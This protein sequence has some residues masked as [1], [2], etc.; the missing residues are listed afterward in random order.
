MPNRMQHRFPTSSHKGFYGKRR[1]GKALDGERLDK[2]GKGRG[3]KA[4]AGEENGEE[5][6]GKEEKGNGSGGEGREWKAR[7]R[8]GRGGEG[9]GGEE[10]ERHRQAHNR[11]GTRLNDGITKGCEM[12]HKET[13]GAG[14]EGR[15]KKEGWDWSEVGASSVGV[16][17][18][19]GLAP[20]R[21]AVSAS[22]CALATALNSLTTPLHLHPCHVN[23]LPSICHLP[24]LTQSN[25][26]SSKAWKAC[27]NT[28]RICHLY[29]QCEAAVTIPDTIEPAICHLHLYLLS[30]PAIC[31]SHLYLPFVPGRY[32]CQVQM[33]CAPPLGKGPVR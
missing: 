29:L 3:G 23:L 25:C 19:Y 4:R 7:R 13:S 31:T 28:K 21:T 6:R 16:G 11:R 12:M 1:A 26:S 5:G 32:I 20:R 24:L 14:R 9:R 8:E 22:F 17:T 15:T 33:A 2:T 27:G 30:V 18:W 10:T